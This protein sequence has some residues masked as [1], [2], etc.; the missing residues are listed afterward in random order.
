MNLSTTPPKCS[1]VRFSSVWYTRSIALT[2][3]GS[4]WS[5]R[6]VNPTRSQNTTVMTLRSSPVDTLPSGD[7]Q[8]KQKRAPCGFLVPHRGQT[9]TAPSLATVPR[10]WACA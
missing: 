3:S 2:S 6:S 5:E 1:I 8:F 4:A 7:P 10:C 9:I